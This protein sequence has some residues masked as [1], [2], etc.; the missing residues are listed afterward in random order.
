MTLRAGCSTQETIEHFDRMDVNG[1]LT[2]WLGTNLNEF[3]YFLD[4][5]RIF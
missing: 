1:Q 2:I 3:R 4:F 5:Q